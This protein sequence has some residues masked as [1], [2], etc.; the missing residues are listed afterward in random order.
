MS[1]FI[2]S[3]AHIDA[4][5]TFVADHQIP[6]DCSS[7]GLT[8]LG[9]QILDANAQGFFKRYAHRSDVGTFEP[10][11][12]EFK[13]GR[14]LSPIAFVKAASCARYQMAEFEGWENLP[15]AQLL[16]GWISRTLPKLRGWEEAAWSIG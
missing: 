3:D 2:V 15:G 6:R 13:R 8:L 10:S 7:E 16:A 12:Y 4:L 11:A 5:L 9:R 14:E 1:S